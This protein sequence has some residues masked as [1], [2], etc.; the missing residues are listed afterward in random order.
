MGVRLCEELATKQTLPLT[1]NKF[2]EIVA[3]ILIHR[4]YTNAFP[5]S[6]I[7][8]KDKVVCKN[9]NKP[10]QWGVLKPGNFEPFPKNPHIAQIFTQMGRSEELGTGIQNVFRY[11]KIYSNTENNDFIDDDIFITTVHLEIFKDPNIENVPLN[12]P[13]NNRQKDILKNNKITQLELANNYNVNEKT[14]KRDLQYL[15]EK[16]IIKRIGSKKTGYWKIINKND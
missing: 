4:E 9:A 7:I 10:H 6:F 1:E 2:R 12:V 3:N 16:N 13:L 11:N 8:Y 5:T 14:I 15:Q